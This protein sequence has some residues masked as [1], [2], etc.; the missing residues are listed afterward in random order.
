[1]SCKKN[2]VSLVSTQCIEDVESCLI[3]I[4]KLCTGCWV[5]GK[6]HFLIN[7]SV[8][9]ND[10]NLQYSTYNIVGFVLFNL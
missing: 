6:V 4:G 9:G 3:G 2:A 7:P 10:I 1:M 5:I 8:V